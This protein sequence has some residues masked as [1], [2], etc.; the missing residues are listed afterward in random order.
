LCTCPRRAWPLSCALSPKAC[1]RAAARRA[2]YLRMFRT[3]ELIPPRHTSPVTAPAI[4]R[5]WPPRGDDPGR[6]T[7]RRDARRASPAG[8][9]RAHPAVRNAPR[10]ARHTGAVDADALPQA[11]RSCSPALRAGTDERDY[12]SSHQRLCT[13]RR[14][15]RRVYTR[16]VRLRAHDTTPGRLG[17]MLHRSLGARWRCCCRCPI[18]GSGVTSAMTIAPHGT[19]AV[20]PRCWA[21]GTIACG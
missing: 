15:S 2:G 6:G 14:G 1:V 13:I 16:P 7:A 3:P 18:L 11:V 19:A 9:A 5:P 20:A 17:C 12:S 21:L 8:S 4:Q 10:S